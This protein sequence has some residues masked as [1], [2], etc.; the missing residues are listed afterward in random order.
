MK[1]MLDDVVAEER[2]VMAMLGYMQGTAL[3]K[4]IEQNSWKI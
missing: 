1:T 4:I 3:N 2:D